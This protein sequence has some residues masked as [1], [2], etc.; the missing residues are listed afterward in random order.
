MVAHAAKPNRERES[1]KQ[2][3]RKPMRS[4][5]SAYGTSPAAYSCA[6]GNQREEPFARA[7]RCGVR[8]RKRPPAMQASVLAARALIAPAAP[9]CARGPGAAAAC[10]AVLSPPAPRTAPGRQAMDTLSPK[11]RPPR[12][13]PHAAMTYGCAN[14]M[15]P[16]AAPQAIESSAVRAQH[17]AGHE[18]AEA[19]PRPPRTVL[20]VRNWSAPFDSIYS[21]R[22]LS[23]APP[24]PAAFDQTKSPRLSGNRGLSGNLWYRLSAPSHDAIAASAAM[25]DGRLCIGSQATQG[26]CYSNCHSLAGTMNHKSGAFVKGLAELHPKAWIDASPGPI[27]RP[28]TKTKSEAPKAEPE[29]IPLTHCPGRRAACSR[30]CI[31]PEL[32]THILRQPGG[33]LLGSVRSP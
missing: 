26:N 33:D 17:P 30:Q 13:W 18:T 2:I 5:S 16:P 31:V 32:T 14:P 11:P 1:V 4:R 22:Y 25:P 7:K 29:P 12:R 6:R 28:L 19:A 23:L 15:P 8:T 21:S 20:R 24:V 3:Q 9:G 10:G 27:G